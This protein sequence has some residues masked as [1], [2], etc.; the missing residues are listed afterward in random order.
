LTFLPHT[1]LKNEDERYMEDN[2]NFCS[3]SCE[4]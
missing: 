2:Y 1:S 3:A 4:S